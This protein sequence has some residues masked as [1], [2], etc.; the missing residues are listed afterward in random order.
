VLDPNWRL[1][2]SAKGTL[3]AGAAQRGSRPLTK[4]K[5]VTVCSDPQLG[6]VVATED[7]GIGLVARKHVG[8]SKSWSL[9]DC[10]QVRLGA[11]TT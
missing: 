7:V 6:F 9:Y 8:D 3:A 11:P 5:L 2:T 4:E 10:S 1:R